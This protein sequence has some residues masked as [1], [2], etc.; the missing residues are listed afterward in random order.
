M[1][2]I[3]RQPWHQFA[4]VPGLQQPR[5]ILLAYDDCIV[6]PVSYADMDDMPAGATFLTPD[7]DSEGDGLA[8]IPAAAV[9]ALLTVEEADA[10]CL[11]EAADQRL[12]N[13]A[14]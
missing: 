6:V 2:R 11:L 5:T 3:A 12:L 4:L 14:Y 1:N 13:C 7:F 9:Q 8:R 10:V